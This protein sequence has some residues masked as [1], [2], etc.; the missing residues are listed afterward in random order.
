MHRRHLILLLVVAVLTLG[1]THGAG[2]QTALLPALGTFVPARKA[3][4]RASRKV[5]SGF[6]LRS[7]PSLDNAA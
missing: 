3:A 2:A 1:G 4:G 6:R 7:S 5:C